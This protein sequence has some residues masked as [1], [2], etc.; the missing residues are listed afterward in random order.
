[1]KNFHLFFCLYNA[2]R[3]QIFRNGVLCIAFSKEKFINEVS[4]YFLNKIFMY[5]PFKGNTYGGVLHAKTKR[6]N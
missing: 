2:S 6:S 1:M 4:L 5:I 3:A